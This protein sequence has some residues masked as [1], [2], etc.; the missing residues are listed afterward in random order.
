MVRLKCCVAD[1]PLLSVTFMVN[2]NVPTWVGVPAS[3]LLLSVGAAVDTSAKPG[4]NCPE[5]KDQL[6]GATPP[7]RKKFYA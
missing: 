7:L 4:G 6:Y 5:A 3:W 1:W 2:L